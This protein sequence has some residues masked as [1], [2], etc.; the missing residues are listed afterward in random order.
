[1]IWGYSNGSDIG[2]SCT[3]SQPIGEAGSSTPDPL[4]ARLIRKSQ[5]NF[6]VDLLGQH[7]DK[8]SPS[9]RRALAMRDHH[10]ALTREVTS[11]A[12][13]SLGVRT[14]RH[15]GHH[16]HRQGTPTGPPGDSP[17]GAYLFKCQSMRRTGLEVGKLVISPSQTLWARRSVFWLSEKPLLVCEYF[18]PELVSPNIL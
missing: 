3:K 7:W 4:T 13:T 8:P 9:E 14:Q 15:S 2:P 16:A 5:G 18:L 11:M 17:L 1:M 10:L 12:G 6:R